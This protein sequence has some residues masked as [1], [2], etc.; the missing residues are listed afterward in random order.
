MP[1]DPNTNPGGDGEVIEATPASAGQKT[2]HIRWVLAISLTLAIAGVLLVW[3][4]T[5]LGR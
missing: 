5:H 1:N 3:I 4:V 2:G